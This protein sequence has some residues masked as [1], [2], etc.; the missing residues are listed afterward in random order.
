MKGVLVFSFSVYN[1]HFSLFLMSA[2]LSTG[3]RINNRDDQTEMN[4][5][6]EYQVTKKG[7]WQRA[8]CWSSCLFM[9][10]WPPPHTHTPVSYADYRGSAVTDSPCSCFSAD[11]WKLGAALA[12]SE[13]GFAVALCAATA[14]L[15]N[16]QSQ[17]ARLTLSVVPHLKLRGSARNRRRVQG[18]WTT[19]RG[20]TDGRGLLI[21]TEKN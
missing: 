18:A 10:L 2:A 17:T 1:I 20:D 4:E 9:L 6:K 3:Q 7:D 12:R 16:C 8:I 19:G 5:R 21:E 15:P 13:N 11:R 14:I